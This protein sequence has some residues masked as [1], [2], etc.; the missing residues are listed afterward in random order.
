MLVTPIV[1]AVNTIKAKID[2][3]LAVVFMLPHEKI[4]FIR[5]LFDFIISKSI[6]LLCIIFVEQ[7]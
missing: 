6:S 3:I 2:N 1:K 7:M 5:A 4:F